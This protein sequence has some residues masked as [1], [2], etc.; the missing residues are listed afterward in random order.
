MGF[1]HQTGKLLAET[2]RE[3]PRAGGLGPAGHTTTERFA[4]HASLAARRDRPSPERPAGLLPRR[5]ALLQA[6]A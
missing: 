3:E 4:G 2:T 1:L 6:S 5:P